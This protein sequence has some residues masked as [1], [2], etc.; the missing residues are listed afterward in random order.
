V[1]NLRERISVCKG[2]RQRFELEGFDLKKLDDIEIKE[3]H[4]VEILNRFANLERVDE[5]FDINNA[6]GKIREILRSQPN[7]I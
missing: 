5:S 3:K 4:Q 1:A 6:W 2:A 7:I